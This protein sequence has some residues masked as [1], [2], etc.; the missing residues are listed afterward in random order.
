MRGRSRW[1]A[2]KVSSVL[3]PGQVGPF[4]GQTR[5]YVG[6]GGTSPRL[7]PISSAIVD[8]TRGVRSGSPQGWCDRTNEFHLIS[9][10]TFFSAQKKFR[11][12]KGHPRPIYS[13]PLNKMP[14][15]SDDLDNGC[16]I[17]SSQGLLCNL[18]RPEGCLLAC[19]SQE[20]LL[21]V[22]GLRGGVR[23]IASEPCLSG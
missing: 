3:E 5:S 15:I 1:S 11:E 2:P 10:S 6:V 23:S 17:N 19:P 20:A 13:E 9:R 8:S 7:S 14:I 18:N 22:S 16:E 21:E 4:G 12:K